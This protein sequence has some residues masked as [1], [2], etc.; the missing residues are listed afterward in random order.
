[1]ALPASGERKQKRLSAFLA[2][3]GLA[4]SGGEAKRLIDQ[5]AVSLDG[6]TLESNVT[7]D[8]LSKGVLKVGKRQFV[9][10]VEP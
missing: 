3:I 8:T 9:R 2:E 10:L 6:V 1:M 4:P 7:L 5:K